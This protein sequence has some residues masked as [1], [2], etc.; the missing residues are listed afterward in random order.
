MQGFVCNLCPCLEYWCIVLCILLSRGYYIVVVPLKKQRPGKFLKPWDN[1]DEM[2]LEEVR[3]VQIW[4]FKFQ[5]FFC[6]P[7]IVVSFLTGSTSLCAHAPQFFLKAG[8]KQVEG[9][10]RAGGTADES[11][12]LTQIAAESTVH[13]EMR[14]WS[15]HQE[16]CKLNPHSPPPP[17]PPLCVCGNYLKSC[18]RPAC[19]FS[20][21]A[22]LG[23][24]V[25][26]KHLT[27]FIF[28]QLR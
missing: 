8:K 5:V 19:L 6:Y 4:H 23:Y 7:V 18:I 10:K 13:M 11:S 20:F 25:C 17:P 15:S 3:K 21:Q 14:T 12:W 1:P 22:E 2:N 28:S 27:T 16:L 9:V 26:T 24:C